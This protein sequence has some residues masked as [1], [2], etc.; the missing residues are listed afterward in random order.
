MFLASFSHLMC[1]ELHSDSRVILLVF[2]SKGLLIFLT[3]L[4]A[5]SLIFLLLA[6][7]SNVVLILRKFSFDFTKQLVQNLGYLLSVW[8]PHNIENYEQVGM[9]SK[10]AW[11]VWSYFLLIQGSVKGGGNTKRQ[12]VQV[13][14]MN[15]LERIVFLC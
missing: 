6:Y 2:D 5:I 15:E 11:H 12:C 10:S 3:I 1:D 13:H 9:V 8:L 4:D 14:S 7:M